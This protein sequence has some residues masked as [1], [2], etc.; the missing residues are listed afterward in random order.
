M[1]LRMS[2]WCRYF[3]NSRCEYLYNEMA[4]ATANQVLSLYAGG[5]FWGLHNRL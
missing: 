2:E 4:N 5:G 1:M 3:N